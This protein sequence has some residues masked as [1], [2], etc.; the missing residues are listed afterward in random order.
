MKTSVIL[1]A[2]I[3]ALLAVS[4]SVH[5][6]QGQ[7]APSKSQPAMTDPAGS[8]MM[9]PNQIRASK[10]IGA[11]VYDGN[12]DKVGTIGDFILDTSGG[13]VA[14][15]V[16]GISGFLGLGDKNVA[17]KMSDITWE[18]DR[19]IVNRSKRELQRAFNYRLTDDGPRVDRMAPP[20]RAGQERS[21]AT[22][23]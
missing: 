23:R 13:D 2:A 7:G 9:M 8:D 17:V 20:G 15:V 18:G 16:I 19:L 11:P 22:G 6:Y 10:V 3:A 21:S 4:A 14:G 12:N 5:A 1:G